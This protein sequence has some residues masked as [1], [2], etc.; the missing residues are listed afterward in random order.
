MEI[1]GRSRISEHTFFS[2]VLNE[3]SV[4]IDLG[5][6]C[7]LFSYE[8]IR[9]FNCRVFSAEPVSELCYSVIPHP[10]LTVLPVA[11][12]GCNGFA[13]LN[14]FRDQ[15][16]S[17]HETASNVQASRMD[18]VEVITFAELQR[19]SGFLKIDLLKIDI[20]GAEI[21]MFSAMDDDTIRSIGQITIEFHD[22][23]IHDMATSVENIKMRLCK[24]G[25]YMI[26]CSLD[27]TD[28][29]FVN[30]AWRGVPLY[31]LVF[32]RFIGRNFD[33]LRRIIRRALSGL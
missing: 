15:C 21:E 26:K 8:I 5:F 19:R 4:V 3:S 2:T 14:V 18:R 32:Y 28:V 1:F 7:G 30:R 25:F 12:G 9:R 20:E 24:L 27:N 17:L 6:N 13:D 33:G 16:A 22:F 31:Q 23:L 29:L 11:L 10:K